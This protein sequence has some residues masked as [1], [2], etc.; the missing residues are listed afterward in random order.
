[1]PATLESQS[2][3][4][5]EGIECCESQNRTRQFFSIPANLY[6]WEPSVSSISA[7]GNGSCELRICSIPMVM[8]LSPD[9]CRQHH[10]LYTYGSNNPINRVD[11][12]GCADIDF[13]N[14]GKRLRARIYVPGVSSSINDL[15]SFHSRVNTIGYVALVTGGVIPPLAPKSLVVDGFADGAAIVLDVLRIT[16]GDKTAY[17]DLKRDFGSLI[18]DEFLGL[19]ARTLKQEIKNADIYIDATELGFDGAK[20]VTMDAIQG[21]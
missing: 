18:L 1:M 7:I 17:Q 19:G 6:I 8:W 16:K 2:Q 20:S 14:H 5:L 4:N 13:D 9:P 3:S 21:E 11:P 15:Q 12:D 10:S